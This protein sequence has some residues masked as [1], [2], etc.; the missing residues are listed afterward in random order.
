LRNAWFNLFISCP[1]CNKTK[2]EKYPNAKPLKPDSLNYNFD[3]WFIINFHNG[4]ILPNPKRSTN[5]KN[6]I[7]ETINWFGLNEES[8]CTAR[9][10]EL[11]FFT[12]NIDFKKN[13][14]DYSYP[15]FLKRS[16]I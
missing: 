9:L 7:S 16:Q 4:K 5:E 13:I 10:E 11:K 3:Y 15:Y 1:K 12:D 8:R 2:W 14:L 6:R